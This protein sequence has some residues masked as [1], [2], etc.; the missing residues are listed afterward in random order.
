[1]SPAAARVS[2][3]LSPGEHGMK[4][5]RRGAKRGANWWEAYWLPTVIGTPS[6]T[7]VSV[8]D[9]E[10]QESGEGARYQHDARAQSRTSGRRVVPP[11][12][13]RPGRQEGSR[14]VSDPPLW[15]ETWSFP[16]FRGVAHAPTPSTVRS[17]ICVLVRVAGRARYTTRSRRACVVNHT[18]RPG[19]YSC[20]R[21]PPR[22]TLKDQAMSVIKPR[23]R[24]KQL[25]PHLTRLDHETNETLY[26]ARVHRAA[27]RPGHR[28]TVRRPQP[29][30]S[31][32]LLSEAALPGRADEVL[33]SPGPRC[34]VSSLDRIL[35]FLRPIEDR[36]R[37]RPSPK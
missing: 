35:P 37:D 16:R 14:G 23:T 28:A 19:A 24:V 20:P 27:E 13:Q 33:R 17:S 26:A 21:P 8:S 10:D 1:M 25:V 6:V 2:P 9:R 31:A 5:S 12:P 4:T 22:S 36:L 32:A 7:P 34:T 15:R 30:S 29:A 3:S 18:S 11:P